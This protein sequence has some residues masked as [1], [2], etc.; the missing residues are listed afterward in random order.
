MQVDG[1]LE[2][3]DRGEARV[4]EPPV[5]WF[6]PDRSGGCAQHNRVTRLFQEFKPFHEHVEGPFR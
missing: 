6:T 5:A 4:R 1:W 3:R 2:S